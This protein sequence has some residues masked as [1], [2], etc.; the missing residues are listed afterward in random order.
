[1][2]TV[3]V[4]DSSFGNT[5]RV[6]QAMASGAGTP[7]SV[8]VLSAAEATARF[9]ERPDLLLVGGPTQR[10]RLSPALRGFLDA[11]PWG[12]LKGVQAASF[13]TRYRMTALLSGSAARD[14]DGGLRK[15]GCRL[16][17][18]PESFFME[19]DL[20][21]KGEKRRDEL[22]T[23]EAGELER[24]QEWGRAVWTAAQ[25]QRST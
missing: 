12:S 22:E 6:A 7:G 19:R 9:P 5:A 3:V 17:A 1:M 25:Q 16:I 4:Y 13:D 18:P 11:L 21:P 14:A 15:A 23:L 10:H 8:R 24:A 20:P 2:L